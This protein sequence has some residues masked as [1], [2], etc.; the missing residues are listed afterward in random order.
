MV[1][2]ASITTAHRDRPSVRCAWASVGSN[3]EKRCDIITACR[4]SVRSFVFQFVL[5]ICFA[6]FEEISSSISTSFEQSSA[7]PYSE[8][9]LSIFIPSRSLL[10]L[11]PEGFSIAHGQQESE[12]RGIVKRRVFCHYLGSYFCLFFCISRSQYRH[13]SPN[14]PLVP[15]VKLIQQ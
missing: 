8:T 3:F 5:R 6:L 15:T 9:Y 13:S 10:L 7:Y 2:C 4:I 1:Q 14:R 11:V 12:T